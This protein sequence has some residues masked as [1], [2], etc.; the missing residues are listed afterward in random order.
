LNISPE[1]CGCWS[2][3]LCSCSNLSI[4]GAQRAAPRGIAC[5]PALTEG[6]H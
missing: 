5:V 1:R 3:T 4:M 2:R 6:G